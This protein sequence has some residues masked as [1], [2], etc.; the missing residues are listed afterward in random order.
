MTEVFNKKEYIKKRQKE[1]EAL[2]IKVL[3]YTNNDVLNNIEGVLCDIVA[4]TPHPPP[5]E[6]GD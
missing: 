2:G 3:R 4:T 5:Y 1:I 6:G